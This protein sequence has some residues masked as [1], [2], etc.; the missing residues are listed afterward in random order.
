MVS[1]RFLHKEN[2][3]DFFVTERAVRMRWATVLEA[4]CGTA[5]NRTVDTKIVN[6]M[7]IQM[8]VPLQRGTDAVC[9]PEE[10]FGDAAC[11]NI[12]MQEVI[13]HRTW[14]EHERLTV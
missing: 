4:S 13:Y 6:T 1:R 2:S 7:V 8:H 14:N 10:A 9:M 5:I 3:Q 12:A 11:A